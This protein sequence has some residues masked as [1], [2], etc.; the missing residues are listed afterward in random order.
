MSR[1][2][3]KISLLFCGGATLKTDEGRLISVTKPSDIEQWLEAVPELSLIADLEPE[4]VFPDGKEISPLDWNTLAQKISKAYSSVEG[5]VLLHSVDTLLYSA[6]SLSFQLQNF[7]KSIVFTGSPLS[8]VMNSEK[9]IENFIT[10]YRGMGV[11]ANFINAIQVATLNIPEVS[12]LFGNQLLRGN[13][14]RKSFSLTFNLFEADESDQL[15][16]VDFGIRV[17]KKI[18]KNKKT[19]IKVETIKDTK[20]VVVRMHPGFNDE[21]FGQLLSLEPKAILFQTYLQEGIPSRLHSYIKIA[22]QREIP[23]VVYNAFTG[24][25]S[26]FKN[27]HMVFGITFDALYTKMIWALSKTKNTSDF[28][29]LLDKDIASEFGEERKEKTS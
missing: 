10:N 1:D 11:R 2:L 8:P 28:F 17:N 4:F 7:S 27:L 21:E 12:I 6:S 16:I 19:K 26:R 14:A 5:F 3:P 23:I 29:Q 25:H 24:A 22:E 13:R 20:I 15:G 9:E 18:E